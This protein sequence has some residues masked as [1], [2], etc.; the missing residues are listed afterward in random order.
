MRLDRE[1]SVPRGF[2]GAADLRWEHLTPGKPRKPMVTAFVLPELCGTIESEG[3]RR[4][5]RFA[6][7]L[8]TACI[9]L[10]TIM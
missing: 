8:N 4:R 1:E 6:R 10:I 7:S 5:A 3:I 9:G 2:K